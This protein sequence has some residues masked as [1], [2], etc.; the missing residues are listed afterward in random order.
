MG[1][2]RI[3]PQIA[4]IDGRVLGVDRD[5][6]TRL[7]QRHQ[8]VATDNEGLL[9]GKSKALVRGQGRMARFEPGS[10]HNG[11]KHAVDIVATRELTNRLRV[12]AE[13]RPLGQLLKHGVIAMSDI[14]HGNGRNRELAGGGNELRGT[15][16]DR[17][18]RHLQ[19][20]GMLTAHIECLRADR[21][22]T[23][24]DGNTKASIGAIRR[25]E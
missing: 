20:I 5:E 6:L 17:Q 24:Q 4:L 10:A 23:S 12:N 9:V 22:R 3:L 18:R 11:N 13:L 14:G 16:I 19:P 1:L 2:A 8:Q 21:A 25:L 15:G 7:G